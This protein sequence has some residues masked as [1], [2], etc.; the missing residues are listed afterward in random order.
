MKAPCEITNVA[1]A[2]GLV[3]ISRQA[4]D[5]RFGTR[6]SLSVKPKNDTFYDF[7]A[8]TGGGVYDFVIHQ[9]YAANL[10]EAREWLKSRGLVS[11]DPVAAF[12]GK[13]SGVLREHIYRNPDGSI[14]R[15]S[16]KLSDG[17]WRQMRYENGTFTPG[18]KGV[19]NVPYG[20]DRLAEDFSD[21][22][23]F[24]F[25]GEKDVERGWDRGLLATCNVGGAK[26]W[27][28]E[29]NAHLKDRT[30]CIVPDNDKAG[31]NHAQ[32]VYASLTKSGID[33][34]ILWD[35]RDGLPDKGDFSDWMDAN[36]DDVDR[37]ICLLRTNR[38]RTNRNRHER[39]CK[40][41][42]IYFQFYFFSWC[43][44]SCRH[45]GLTYLRTQGC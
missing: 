43:S 10:K 29:L 9:G 35:Y 28:D 25:E 38:R 22:L 15:K 6:G 14:N 39:Y 45:A 40:L 16:V 41:G 36:N 20:A 12:N 8:E 1:L 17:A 21:K 18:V 42:F 37:Y 32:K 44:R 5:W 3:P 11:D 27:K 4:D 19:P 7:E 30:V 33:C 24:I 31:T 2:M 13:G 34:F 26:N 23:A